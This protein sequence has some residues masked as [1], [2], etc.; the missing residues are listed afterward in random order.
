M[1]KKTNAWWEKEFQAG[2][3]GGKG[4]TLLLVWVRAFGEGKQVERREKEWLVFWV[5][6]GQSKGK[7]R[8]TYRFNGTVLEVVFIV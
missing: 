1:G 5:Q 4:M 3:E 2:G 6:V 7:Q 8:L